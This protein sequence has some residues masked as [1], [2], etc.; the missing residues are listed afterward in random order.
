ML[1]I[2]VYQSYEYPD[3]KYFLNSV[4]RAASPAHVDFPLHVPPTWHSLDWGIPHT[5]RDLW[6][7]S[8]RLASFSGSFRGGRGKEYILFA[9]AFSQTACFM[10]LMWTYRGWCI[11]CVGEMWVFNVVSNSSRWLNYSCRLCRPPVIS[12]CAVVIFSPTA[13]K[14]RWSSRIEDLL[15]IHVQLDDGLLQNVCP[16]C[17]CRL[18]RTSEDSGDTTTTLQGCCLSQASCQTWTANRWTFRIR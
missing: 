14:E 10:V 16:K 17:K 9:H 7:N 18:E 2:V 11:V 12:K 15:S 3:Y 13:A 1:Y 4:Y 5:Y 8:G 6:Q